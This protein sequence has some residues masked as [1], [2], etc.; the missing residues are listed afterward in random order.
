MKKTIIVPI[1]L[2]VLAFPVLTARAEGSTG[3]E[4]LGKNTLDTGDALKS[5]VTSILVI[6]VL[7]VAAVYV[8]KKVMPKVSAAMG[9][10]LRVV[11][12][13]N[14]GPRKQVYVVKVGTKKLL[15]GA[16][17]ESVTFLADVTE[18]MREPGKTQAEGAKNE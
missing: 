9:K 14:L 6:I 11:E 13:I 18:A 5:L 8:A 16:A 15:I 7:G 12:S 1:F 2:L 10:E 3:L 17:S 4:N